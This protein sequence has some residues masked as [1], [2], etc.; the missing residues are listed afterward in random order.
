M[1]GILKG[2]VVTFK[3]ILRRRFTV[4]YPD[5]KLIL[6]PRYR[7]AL[8]L[9]GVVGE[10]RDEVSFSEE[11]TRQCIGCGICSRICPNKCIELAAS[12]NGARKIDLFKIGFNECMFCGICVRN[13]EEI[14]KLLTI[15]AK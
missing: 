15:D 7:G 5:E 11:K 6:A 4:Q 9:R 14:Q 12:H 8:K 10:E 3:H 2:M 1:I 13:G